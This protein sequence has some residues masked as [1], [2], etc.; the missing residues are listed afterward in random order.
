MP[1]Y[2]TKSAYAAAMLRQSFAQGKYVP[3]DRLQIAKIAKDF[4]LSLTPVR[5]ALFELA[6][7][8]LID[9]QPHRGARV[10]DL[11]IT[12]LAEVYLVRELLES[13]ATRLTAQ[14]A[15]LEQLEAIEERHRL[16]VAAVKAGERARL[17][18]LSDDFHD[19]IYD[20]AQSP[21]LRRLI[22]SAWMAAPSDTFI[23]IEERAPRS[24]DD[25]EKIV[26]AIRSGDADAAEALMRDH[27]RGSLE[28][29]RTAKA[30]PGVQRQKAGR[31]RKRADE[32]V[33][34]DPTVE[35]ARPPTGR[36]S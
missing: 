33:V 22:R 9:L 12:D 11:P 34:A 7:E 29:I 25:H 1:Q 5:E 3:G 26:D 30:K 17:R 16:F 23:L 4:G 2:Q 6:N 32:A 36:S 13:A 31:S 27:V 18:Q 24:V 8:G 35:A 15:T 10:A 21:L 28:L 20:A 19:T 14:R